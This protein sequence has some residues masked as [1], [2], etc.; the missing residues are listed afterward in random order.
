MKTIGLIGGMSWEST[1]T[2]YQVIN[3]AV[4]QKL[5]GFHSAKCL[6]WS[7]DFAEVEGCLA[8]GD[9]EKLGPIIADAAKKLAAAGA[10]FVLIGSNTI[11]RVFETVE[12]AV[13]VP[14]LHIADVTADALQEK[15]IRTVELL[16]TRLTM[17]LDFL[18]QRLRDRGINVLVP[19]RDDRE[20]MNAIVFDEL[21]LGVINPASKQFVLDTI[22]KAQGEGAEGA[23]LGCTEI[24]LLIRQPDTDCPLFDTALIHAAGAARYALE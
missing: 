9:W 16:G 21:C 11:H 24:G 22:A 1:V 15:G 5:G 4:Q 20:R 10:D 8:R 2:Y 18:K 6:L 12:N 7:V 3:Q 19:D 13:S 23:V 14:V 17:E